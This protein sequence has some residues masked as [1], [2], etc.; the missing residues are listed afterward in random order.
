MRVPSGQTFVIVSCK[1][2]GSPRGSYCPCVT[3]RVLEI[4]REQSI[5]SLYWALLGAGSTKMR[6]AEPLLSKIYLSR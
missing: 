2:H 3:D 4:P 5:Y 6:K 1:T